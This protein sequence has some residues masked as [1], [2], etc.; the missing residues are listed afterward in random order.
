M[1]TEQIKEKTAGIKPE[2]LVGTKW[3]SWKKLLGDR[4]SVEF[5]DRKNCIYVSQPNKY[6]MTYNIKE[7][8]L[9]IS[10][11][12]GAFELRGDVLFNNDLPVFEKVA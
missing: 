10:M 7:G 6:Q 2:Q 4:V 11:I 1:K 9:F 12:M 3:L 8:K 5:L